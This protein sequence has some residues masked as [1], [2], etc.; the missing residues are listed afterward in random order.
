[1]SWTYHFQE[2]KS[3]SPPL[4][5]RQFRIKW[6]DKFNHDQAN[7]AAVQ[8]YYKITYQSTPIIKES[9]TKPEI[10]ARIMNA[11]GSSKAELQKLIQDIRCSHPP[12]EGS[13]SSSI[14]NELFHDAQDPYEDPYEDIL[15][16]FI[17]VFT[18]NVRYFVSFIKIKL[19]K[20]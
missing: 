1:M 6:W 8:H 15:V 20:V 19:S 3:L 5:N 11:A 14:K 2:A 18:F 9:L 7:E 4:L 10:V 12:S 13:P 17:L 16:E